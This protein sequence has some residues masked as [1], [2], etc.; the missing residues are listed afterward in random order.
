MPSELKILCP[1]IRYHIKD[2]G[3]CIASVTLARPM[4]AENLLIPRDIRGLMKVFISL[5][6]KGLVFM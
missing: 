5:L 2:R 3:V 6:V 4:K 1:M